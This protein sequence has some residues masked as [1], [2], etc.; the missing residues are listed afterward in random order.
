[1]EKPDL[2]AGR[3]GGRRQSFVHDATV[4]PIQRGCQRLSSAVFQAL[5][6]CGSLEVVAV[7]VEIQDVQLHLGASLPPH[8]L[9]EA[10]FVEGP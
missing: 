8:E 9:S 5:Q 3:P 10:V 4:S 7:R 6:I 2:P 1:M